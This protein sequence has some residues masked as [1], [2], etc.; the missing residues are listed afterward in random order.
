MKTSRLPSLRLS[1]TGLLMQ[2][3]LLLIAANAHALPIM[4]DHAPS[5]GRVIVEDFSAY[6]PQDSFH[7]DPFVIANGTIAEPAG[8]YDDSCDLCVG[9]ANEDY[10][11]TFYDLPKRTLFWSADFFESFGLAVSTWTVTGRS[12]VS[13]FSD[14]EDA[15]HMAFFD[16]RGLLSIHVHMTNGVHPETGDEF[17]E[18]YRFD[19]ITTFSVP[20]AGG[21]G[22]L[23]AA[24]ALL[25]VSYRLR[26]LRSRRT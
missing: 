21:V 9:L 6:T 24:F 4:T 22:V 14:L 5:R 2:V 19:N 7:E 16:P 11:V 13:V 20:E 18:Y 15:R 3:G 12:G 1:L 10:E 8:V 25:L 23:C 26:Q 17:I